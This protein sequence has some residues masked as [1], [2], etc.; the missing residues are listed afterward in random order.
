MLKYPTFSVSGTLI[1]ICFIYLQA[2]KNQSTNTRSTITLYQGSIFLI[3]QLLCF[4]ILDTFRE[5]IKYKT[6]INQSSGDWK[7]WIFQHLNWD[8]PRHWQWGLVRNETLRQNH[9]SFITHQRVCN[10]SSIC[11]HSSLMEGPSYICDI[12]YLKP[13]GIAA[14]NKITKPRINWGTQN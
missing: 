7:G 1:Y 9:F 10:K 8:T 11:V 12:F 3:A 13:N 2:F 6:Y 4:V 14:I 5:W